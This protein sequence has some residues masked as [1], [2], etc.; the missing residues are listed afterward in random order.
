VRLVNGYVTG[1][2]AVT[3]AQGPAKVPPEKNWP[4][5]G[6][7][8]TYGD[9]YERVRRWRMQPAKE[10]RSCSLPRQR[11]N[12]ELSHVVRV[13]DYGDIQWSD[14]HGQWDLKKDPQILKRGFWTKIG[15]RRPE[16]LGETWEE[17]MEKVRD[18]MNDIIAKAQRNKRRARDAFIAFE[19]K[20]KM[21]VLDH[22]VADLEKETNS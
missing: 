19:E 6:W 2:T 18:H 17:A 16:F 7:G 13:Q 11:H 15:W 14:G 20:N 21:K 22:I 1:R 5:V 8:I 10:R 12:P 9:W 4:P 3:W